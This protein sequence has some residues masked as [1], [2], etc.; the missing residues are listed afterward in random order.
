LV[1]AMKF[2][3]AK[4]SKLGDPDFMEEEVVNKLM[5]DMTSPKIGHN[6]R[7]KI[8]DDTTHEPSYYGIEV[9]LSADKGTTHV[10]ILAENGDAVSATHSINAWYGSFYKSPTTGILYNNDMN[11]FSTQDTPS[12]FGFPPSPTNY[13]KPGKRPISAMAPFILVD[14]YGRVKMVLGC[15][16]GPR[17]MTASVSVLIH[18]FWFGEELGHA[19]TKPRI[20][21]QLIPNTVWVETHREIPEFIQEGLKK[22][23]HNL[24]H[25]EKP[26][27]SA[28]QAVYFEG[29]GS[30]Y[31]KSDPRKYGHSAGY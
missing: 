30:I 28:C 24:T 12:R 14:K 20:H 16:G 22:K 3:Y 2:G 31:A 10:S 9:Q 26:E 7:E 19:I 4:Y 11:D 25:I 5:D 23:G 29:V 6:I 18:K 27:M 8:S 15:S 21:H 13:I 1:E 17:I